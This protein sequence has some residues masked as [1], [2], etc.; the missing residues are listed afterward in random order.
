MP[1]ASIKSTAPVVRAVTTVGCRVGIIYS[2]VAPARAADIRS[3]ADRPCGLSRSDEL[4]L[5]SDG[6]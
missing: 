4:R 6:A 2:S 1:E 3:D 5:R